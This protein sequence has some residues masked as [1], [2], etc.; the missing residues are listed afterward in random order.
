MFVFSTL[1]I[2]VGVI[3][4]LGII[5]SNDP[6]GNKVKSNWPLEYTNNF[7]E[8]IDL[9]ADTPFVTQ[10]GILSLNN[11]RLWLQILDG[12][13]Y[14]VYAH[15]T[16]STQ[17]NHYAPIDFLALYQIGGKPGGTVCAGTVKSSAGQWTY[18]IGFPMDIEK[19]TMYLN[20]ESFTGG[21]SIIIMLMSSAVLIMLVS[22]AIFSVWIIRHMRKM[23]QAIGQISYRL[24]EPIKNNGP[25]GEIYGSLNDMSR[26]LLA[27]DEAL[28]CNEAMREEWITNITHDL[29]TPLSPIKGYA[30]LLA[31]P[32][33]PIPDESRI[34][35][36]RTILKN[37][38]YAE[39]LVNDLKLTYQLKNN[40]LPLDRK[41]GNL[42]R[43]LREA[44]IEI[45]NHPAY[46]GRIILFDSE[47]DEII[48]C[49]DETLLTRALNNLIF[50][51]LL[52]NPKNTEVHI[53]LHE[54]EH[55]T[56]AVDDNGKGMSTEEAEKLFKR[57]YRGTNTEAGT[58][59]TGLGMAISQQ[60]IELHGGNITVKS[61]LGKGTC[62]EITLPR[63]N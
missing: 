32:A 39:K 48:F 45:L 44:V 63:I 16:A 19:V 55:I 35:Y 5:T 27:S 34:Q 12:S 40:M 38:E 6:N 1:I 29:K 7:A 11:N 2:I 49:F 4:M 8:Y 33:Y 24:Y 14:Q 60:V 59:G 21:R 26:E 3:L 43:F 46:S 62:I 22:G 17:P 51:A 36:A 58:E 9:S 31:D 37:T 54:N 23:T 13:G 57:Y 10:D 53:S 28:A 52:H 56:I 42:V 47:L 25:F 20:G 15:N 30:E 61:E 18:V 50:N 41:Q